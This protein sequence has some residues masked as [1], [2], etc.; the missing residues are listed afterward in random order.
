MEFNCF[1]LLCCHLWPQ[2][3]VTWC[4]L[5]VPAQQSGCLSLSLGKVLIFLFEQSHH[6]HREQSEV[7]PFETCW[8]SVCSSKNTKASVPVIP[9]NLLRYVASSVRKCIISLQWNSL[10]KQNNFVLLLY[11]NKHQAFRK[12][13]HAT[14]STNMNALGWLVCSRVSHVTVSVLC[15]SKHQEYLKNILLCSQH[16]ESA[17]IY[18][19]KKLSR[20]ILK[21]FF[22][23]GWLKTQLALCTLSNK[24]FPP[25]AFQLWKTRIHMFR[26][27]QCVHSSLLKQK[28]SIK[29][30]QWQVATKHT[31][32]D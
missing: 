18:R 31:F 17:W 5:C 13:Q 6:S 29:C 28:A 12:Y 16:L 23:C 3:N 21:D 19:R 25:P 27:T 11:A 9:K 14:I 26:L 4:S 7:R 30:S 10:K 15:W 2:W 20:I 8:S 24:H 22:L 32:C 1:R